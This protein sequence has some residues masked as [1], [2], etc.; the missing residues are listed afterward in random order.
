M[1]DCPFCQCRA[2]AEPIQGRSGWFYCNGCGKTFQP[3]V[4]ISARDYR[5][6]IDPDDDREL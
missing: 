4:S 6:L 2:S 1:P 5:R 3:N